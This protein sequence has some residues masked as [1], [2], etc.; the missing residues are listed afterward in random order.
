MKTKTVFFILIIGLIVGM[1]IFS[2]DQEL[3][4]FEK[5]PVLYLELPI[6]GDSDKPI[7]DIDNISS[8]VELVPLIKQRR[9]AYE[10]NPNSIH[11]EVLILHI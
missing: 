8:H 3:S 2:Y 11:F 4:V 6:K 7:I 1:A 9:A 10:L 5:A